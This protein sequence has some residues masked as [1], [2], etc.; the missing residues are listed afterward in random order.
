MRGLTNIE[1]GDRAAEAAG[2]ATAVTGVIHGVAKKDAMVREKAGG[3]GV[4][5]EVSISKMESSSLVHSH[6]KIYLS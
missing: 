2:V 3:A 1:N 4:G 5:R 6:W